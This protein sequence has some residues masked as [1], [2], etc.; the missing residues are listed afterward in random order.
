MKERYESF[1][2]RVWVSGRQLLRGQ[3]THVASGDATRFTE[4]SDVADFIKQ[5]VDGEPATTAENGSG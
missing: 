5:Q 2:V 3:V 4:V 1:V